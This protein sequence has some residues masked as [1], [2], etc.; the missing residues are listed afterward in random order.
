MFEEIDLF[1]VTG[2][3]MRYLTERQAVISRNIA[4]ADTPHYRAQDLRPFSI[5]SALLKGGV[6]PGRPGA[7]AGEAATLQMARTRGGHVGQPGGAAAARVT[8]KGESYDEKVAGNTV[9]LEEQMLKSAD[10]TNSFALATAAYAKSVTLMKI[11]IG[12]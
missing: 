2:A 6:D 10:V 12:R 5:N 11:G 9:S 3:R 1:R 4:N 7:Q 8:A